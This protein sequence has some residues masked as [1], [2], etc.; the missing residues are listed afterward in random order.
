MKRTALLFIVI[1]LGFSKGIIGQQKKLDSLLARSNAW[2]QEDSLK[3]MY[4]RDV[5]RAYNSVKNTE[6]VD[7]YID[8][9]ILIA[10]KLP[11]KNM[12]AF[13]YYRAGGIFHNTN[14][15]RAITYYN[16]SIEV[17]RANNLPKQ[18]ADA[19]LNLG[20]LYLDIRDYPKSLDAHDHALQGFLQAK[21]EG[22]ASSCYMNLSYIFKNTGQLVKA[23]EYTR[24]ALK[25]FET[26][27]VKRGVAVAY[28]GIIDLYFESTDAELTQMGILPAN[29]YR[30]IS[31]AIETGLKA[32]L[33]TDDKSV[34]SN[35]YAKS[36]KLYELQGNF[37]QAQQNYTKAVDLLANDINEE[38]YGDNLVIA[39]NFYIDK[40]KNFSKGL[41]M[42]HWALMASRRLKIRGTEQDALLSLSTAHE[43]QQHFDSSL[44]Y[45]RQAIVVKDSIYSKEKE[46]EIT[47]R[48]LKIDFDIKERDYKNAQQ[49]ADARMKQ[50]EQQILLRNQQLQISDKEK[51]LQRLT[52]L[53]KQAE[54]ENHEKL[55]A[56]LMV[57]KQQKADF[58]KKTSDQQIKVQNVQLVSNQ[59]LSVFLG[60]LAVIV[61]AVAIFIFESRKKTVRLNKTVS[62]QK[63]ALEEL[64][65]VKD[66]IFSVVSHD[67]R[68]PVNSIIAFS[69]LLADGDIEQ[70]RLA[71]YVDQIKGTLDHT[72]SLMENLLNWASS[73]M[74]GFAPVIEEI[75]IAPIVQQ[76]IQGAAQALHKKKIT[77][78]NAITEN[79]FVKGDMN[80]IELI[81]RNIVNNAVKFSNTGGEL[82]LSVNRE[83]NKTIISVS[84]NGVGID[85]R[86][87]AIINSPSAG[88]IHST[89]GTE[90]EKGT[91][92][93][94]M[95][96]KQFA[97]LMHGSIQV[98]SRWGNGSVFSMIL[99]AA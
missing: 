55:Q 7:L 77:V 57:Q 41:E 18:Q 64:V 37:T 21:D 73:Q 54:L 8:S 81:L 15:L 98:E 38:S 13:A 43:K 78:H 44:Y 85:D 89:F 24:K 56:N 60:V 39:G 29:R 32:A 86:K 42:L 16:K 2:H 66:K 82:Q 9:A 36:G 59:R 5:F 72:A 97:T 92:L 12:L 14:R 31:T 91:G 69:S 48:Q 95:L 70:K 99:P 83:G 20:A 45:Y 1:L 50:Q 96:C 28:E 25:V 68:V 76:T 30:E 19:Y 84:D 62:E 90:R 40:V 10:G 49:L 94:L 46:Q 34:I 51:T 74:Q 26:D 4:L 27:E 6:K 87:V 88:T 17:A 33:T 65:A 79:A 93:G 53:Q 58:D 47:R 11:R 52:F 71:L 61:F 63:M 75:N 3:V 35:L 80:M 67:M 23:M 22:G